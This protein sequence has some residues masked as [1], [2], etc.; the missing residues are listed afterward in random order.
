MELAMFERRRT[1]REFV[2]SLRDKETAFAI[3]AW[4]GFLP[5]GDKHRMECIATKNEENPEKG[6]ARSRIRPASALSWL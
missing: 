3:R 4:E 5:E 2:K 6:Q 1:S